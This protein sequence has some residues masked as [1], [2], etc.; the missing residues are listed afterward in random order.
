MCLK[1]TI[2]CSW[3]IAEVLICHVYSQVLR[4]SYSDI[5]KDDRRSRQYPSG[6]YD[7][8]PPNDKYNSDRKFQ[9]SGAN[10][11]SRDSR[12]ISTQNQNDPST[13]TVSVQLRIGTVT[14]IN[15]SLCDG[16]GV[17]ERIRPGS[18]SNHQPKVY[19]SIAIFLGIPY[20]VSPV[21]ERRFKVRLLCF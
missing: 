12:C 14:G 6:Y 10:Y 18:R 15:F 1:F 20:A 7:R 4:N 19:A 5:Y 17:D 11:P 21:K 16:P 9:T 2:V 3:I 13:S 8:Y